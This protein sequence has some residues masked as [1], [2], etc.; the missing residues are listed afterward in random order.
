MPRPVS[1]Q[2]AALPIPRLDRSFARELASEAQ[3]E[4][5]LPTARYLR[6]DEHPSRI[7]REKSEASDRLGEIYD[8][9]LATDL[10]LAGFHRKRRD[11]VLALPRLIVPDDAS[12]RAREIADFCQSAIAMIPAFANNLAHQLDA[13]AK[14]IA[15]E[16]L[17]WERLTRGPL[18]GAWVPVEMIDRPMWRFAY[19]GGALHIRRPRGADPLAAPPGKFLIM[20]HGTKDS[21][22]GQALLDEVYWAWWLKKN[23]LKFFA[24]FLDKWAQPTAV[25]KYRHRSGGAEAE[26]ANAHDQTQLLA[27]IEA[28]QTEY[29]IVIPEGMAVELLEATRSGSASYENFI[30][31]LTRSQALAFLGEVDTSGAG[32]TT[33]SYARAK[34]SNEVRME[35]VELDARELAAHLRD[36]LL[37]LLVA[38]NFGLDAPVPRVLIDTMAAGDRALRQKGMAAVLELGLPVS[39]RELYLV[40]Q[41][42]EPGPGEQTVTRA[43]AGRAAPPATEAPEPEPPPPPAGED[44]EEETDYEKRLA[45]PPAVA[46]A[47]PGLDL[48]DLEAA[49]AA[50]D[51]ELAT[52]AAGLVD[53]SLAHYQGLLAAVGEAWDSGAAEAGLLLQTVVEHGAPAAH[54]EALEVALIHGCGLALR[55]LQEELGER[56]I[57]FAAQPP[58]AVNTPAS[59]LDYWA[60]V[61]GLPREEFLA[62]TDGARRF[63]F[64][65]AGVEDAALLADLQALVGRAVAE[66][67]TREEFV[68]A[69]EALFAQRGL[70]PLSRWHLEIVFANNVR[71]AAALMRYQQLVLNPAAHRLMPYLVWV[72][73]GDD[74]VRPAHAAMHGYIAPPTADIW[75]TWWPP[76]GHNCRCV[77]EGINVAKARRLG[78]TGAE[79]TGPWPLV[80]QDG[81]LPTLAMPDPGFV[82]APDFGELGEIASG[83]LAEA[84]AAATEAAEAAGDAASPEQ[85]DLLESL[86]ALLSAL[87][88]TGLDRL[89]DLIARIRRFLG[90]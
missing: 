58:T 62:L 27:A 55:Q 86:I 17:L 19:V 73:M 51:G 54:G 75:R 67:L 41:V 77:V 45:A 2:A 49:A 46:L 34:V 24:V 38:V 60:R 85:R 76:A 70:T 61:L 89:S 53:R 20:R 42:S 9:M 40:H 3:T 66:G 4:A 88:L 12:P 79:P 26:K 11:A 84:L 28:M 39:R 56:V 36:N 83:R 25:G 69:A 7:V 57:R 52:L 6:E 33:G 32:K 50:R 59:A 10:D 90:R 14:G 22:W 63:A 30:A 5:V 29:G 47:G 68:A 71:N 21:P 44:D 78:L 65:V 48:A 18:A 16:E 82:G 35:K 64:T 8:R 80:V 1:F 43:P 87:G 15:F 74:R 23:G 72:T 31:L 37:R 81:E 13:R